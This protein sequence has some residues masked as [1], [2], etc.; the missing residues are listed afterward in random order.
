MVGIGYWNSTDKT[1]GL[2]V[3]NVYKRLLHCSENRQSEC[4]C[5]QTFPTFTNIEFPLGSQSHYIFIYFEF[6]TLKCLWNDSALS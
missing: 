2:G 4:L 3:R 1:L 5:Y 6:E